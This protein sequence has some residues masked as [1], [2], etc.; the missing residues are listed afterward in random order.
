MARIPDGV[1]RTA[2][3]GGLGAASGR[4]TWMEPRRVMPGSDLEPS[5]IP[6]TIESTNPS[7]DTLSR[8]NPNYNPHTGRVTQLSKCRVR[9]SG[10]GAQ[11]K[12]PDFG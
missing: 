5:V 4:V 11:L 2:Q 6:I 8:Q 12:G 10:A 9:P 3:S 1:I 7:G